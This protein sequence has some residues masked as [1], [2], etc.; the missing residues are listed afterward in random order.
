MMTTA[1]VLAALLER[2]LTMSPVDLRVDGESKRIGGY[3]AVFDSMSRNLGGF[4]E[5]VARSAFNQ[6]R[7]RGWP[8]VMARFNH[9]SNML[10]GTSG[11]G[12]LQLRIDETGLA[13]EVQPPDGMSL[14]REWVQRGDVRKSSFAFRTVS[15]E[16]GAT[17]GGYPVRTLAEVQL[18][19]V[20]PVVDPAYEATSAG[21]RYMDGTTHGQPEVSAGLESLARFVGADLEEVRSAAAEDNLRK[22]LVRTDSPAAPKP[23]PRMFGPAARASLEL[24]REP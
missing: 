15:D 1:P 12:T 21:L 3:A 10:L 17:D 13:Y 11:A 7:S 8:D 23:S 2:K 16:W 4:K 14:V 20:A 22:F 6:S 24:R 9:D 18:V 19:D 5:I